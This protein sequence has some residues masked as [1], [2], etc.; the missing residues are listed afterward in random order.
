MNVAPSTIFWVF[1]MTRPGIEP[2][3]PG[4]W[5][6]TLLIRPIT[7]T[8]TNLNCL[9]LFIKMTLF[10]VKWTEKDWYAVKQYNQLTYLEP[11]NIISVTWDSPQSCSLSGQI[12]LIACHADRWGWL[13]R[14]LDVF[15]LYWWVPFL[16]LGQI[17]LS[18]ILHE[19][20]RTAH[21]QLARSRVTLFFLLEFVS[22][23][24]AQSRLNFDPSLSYERLVVDTSTSV[25]LFKS[26]K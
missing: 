23:V 25:C 15:H 26:V 2:R 9:K 8:Y 21:N 7:Y 16:L 22:E 10:R 24:G 18:F 14:L 12:P 3:S 6:N 19:M 20:L 4:P 17:S 5:V 13:N 1:G 11:I